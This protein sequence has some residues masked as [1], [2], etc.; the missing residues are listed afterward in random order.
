MAPLG[1][2]RSMRYSRVV[3][4][5]RGFTLIELLVVLSLISILAAMGMVQHRNSVLKAQEATLKTDLFHMRD[6]IDKYFA[7][8][9]NTRV[10]RRARDRQLP[11]QDPRRS[12]YALHGIVADRPR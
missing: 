3:P 5:E 12:A 4:G 2:S 1:K 8:K 6:A 10:A 7:D 9:G 11:A